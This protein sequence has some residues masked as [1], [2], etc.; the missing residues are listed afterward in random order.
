[1]YDVPERSPHTVLDWG[2]IHEIS[3][4]RLD[5]LLAFCDAFARRAS[6]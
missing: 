3:S 1:V 4:T 6:K 2:R 5:D